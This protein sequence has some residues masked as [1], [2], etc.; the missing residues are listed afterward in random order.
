MVYT[1][2]VK[3]KNNLSL[4]NIKD[5]RLL[6]NNNFLYKMAVKKYWIVFFVETT[7]FK[8][9]QIKWHSCIVED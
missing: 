2:L 4:N 8:A 7:V 5:F 6:G 1:V 9:F 3:K